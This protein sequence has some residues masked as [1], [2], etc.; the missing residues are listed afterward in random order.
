MA[1]DARIDDTAVRALFRDLGGMVGLYAD[2]RIGRAA[3][4]ARGRVRYG[5]AGTM[6]TKTANLEARA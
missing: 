2:S 4:T 3:M 6:C 1:N 5:S